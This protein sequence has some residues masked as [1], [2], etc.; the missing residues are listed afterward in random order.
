VWF[1]R[2]GYLHRSSAIHYL[3]RSK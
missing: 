3:C 2:E 1:V